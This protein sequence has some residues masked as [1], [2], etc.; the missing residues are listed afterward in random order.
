MDTLIKKSGKLKV[1]HLEDS[2]RDAE[3]LR[4]SLKEARF[5]LE[6]DCTMTEK[7]FVSFLSRS[8]YDIILADFKLPGFDAFGALRHVMEICPAVP[9]ICVSGTIGEE[10]A[11]ELLKQGAVDYVMKDRLARLPASIERAF[12]ESKEKELRKRAEEALHV[13]HSRHKRFIDSNIVG[14]VIADADGKII[15]TN[16]Y[17]LN[18][19]GVSRREFESGKVDWRAM[20]PTEWLPA[21]EKAIKELRE[22]GTCTPYE[23]EYRRKDGTRIPVFLA[24][25]L[26]PGTG[27]AHCCI[28]AGYCRTQTCRRIFTKKR[29]ATARHS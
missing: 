16:D 12:N 22:R 13:E 26:L 7:E 1:L 28:C 6:I 19:L 8:T 4:E 9:F 20:T 14:V 10:S 11:V 2:P 17:Y 25:T 5:D 29:S 3:I 18:L 15:E 27:G 21:D 23:K 24:D